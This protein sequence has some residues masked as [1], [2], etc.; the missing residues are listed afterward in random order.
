VPGRPPRVRMVRCRC[1]IFPHSRGVRVRRLHRGRSSRPTSKGP[2]APSDRDD[3]HDGDETATPAVTK[4]RPKPTSHVAPAQLGSVPGILAPRGRFSPSPTAGRRAQQGRQQRAEQTGQEDAAE[5]SETCCAP[6]TSRRADGEKTRPTRGP[7]K[8]RTD[9]A[10]DSR[11][12]P[13]AGSTTVLPLSPVTPPLP[14][15]STGVIR[16]T[17][18]AR[19]YAPLAT[20]IRP[21]T[22]GSAFALTPRRN[23]STLT[24]SHTPRNPSTD[25]GGRARRAHSRASDPRRRRGRALERIS[26]AS[27]VARR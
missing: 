5:S 6:Q 14:D 12:A 16:W 25:A 21:R 22:L 11:R 10:D 20:R 1:A 7:S 23:Q 3:R 2:A 8:R 19:L 13:I 4:S 24:A 26:V 18:A 27:G 17:P 15:D 9:Q